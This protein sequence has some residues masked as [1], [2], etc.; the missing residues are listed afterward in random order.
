MLQIEGLIFERCEC[1]KGSQGLMKEI[2]FRG[3]GAWPILVTII[4]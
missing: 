1:L 2:G 4:L 3:F